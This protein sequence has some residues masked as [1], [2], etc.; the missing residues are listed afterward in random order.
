MRPIATSSRSAQS[1]TRWGTEARGGESGGM[2]AR[3]PKYRM[4]GVHKV[5]QLEFSKFR[6]IKNVKLFEH[7]FRDNSIELIRN[8]CFA[9]QTTVTREYR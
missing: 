9:R 6:P 7:Y 4:P 2:A 1:F 8:V 5:R 3:D